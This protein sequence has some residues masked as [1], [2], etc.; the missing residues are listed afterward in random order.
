MKAKLIAFGEIEIDGQRYAHDV[1]IPLCQDRCRPL[2]EES[3]TVAG[4]PICLR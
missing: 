4:V 2:F 3:C 1:V